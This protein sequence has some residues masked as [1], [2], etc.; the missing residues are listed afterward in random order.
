MREDV[1]KRQVTFRRLNDAGSEPAQ[2]AVFTNGELKIDYAAGCVFLDGTELHLTPIEYKLLCL[3]S[4]NVGKVLTHTFITQEIWGSAWDNDVASLRVF[5]ATLQK[6]I[7]ADPSNPSTSRPTS[8]WATG[9]S[10]SD[11]A[12]SGARRHA[13]IFPQPARPIPTKNHPAATEH[14]PSRPGGF[15]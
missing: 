3:F 5:M 9:C 6:K 7:E 12:L 11:A 10:K 1:Y 13:G 15:V 8:A 14:N 4:K 2:D